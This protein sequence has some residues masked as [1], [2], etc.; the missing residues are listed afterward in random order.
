M[1]SKVP[2]DQ[3][4]EMGRDYMLFHSAVELFQNCVFLAFN[5]CGYSA[6]SVTSV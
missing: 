6:F 3:R 5:V 1:T 2:R 4:W